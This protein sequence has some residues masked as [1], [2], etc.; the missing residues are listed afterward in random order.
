MV[1]CLGLGIGRER[2]FFGLVWL[3]LVGGLGA[4]LV[5]L[6]CIGGFWGRGW[7]LF[8]GWMDCIGWVI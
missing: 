2:L 5:Y 3:W 6:R 1:G 7:G 8:G 4:R